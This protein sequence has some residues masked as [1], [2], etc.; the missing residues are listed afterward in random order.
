MIRKLFFTLTAVCIALS[1]IAQKEKGEGWEKRK[2]QIYSQK[3]AFITQ[4]LELSTEESQNFWPL[5][6]DFENKKEE[7][8][9]G[10]V[11]KVVHGK[12]PDFSQLTNDDADKM[13]EE[14]FQVMQRMLDLEKD[15]TTKLKKVIPSAKVVRLQYVE[16]EFK[17]QLLDQLRSDRRAS[18]EK[19]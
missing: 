19:K 3:V 16:M 13:I 1:G 7:I 9:K 17:R 5:Y 15:F 4:K 10:R 14:H 2:E 6:N 12:H 11:N 18:K 8:Q